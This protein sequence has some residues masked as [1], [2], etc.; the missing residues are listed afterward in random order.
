[1]APRRKKAATREVSPVVESDPPPAA[2]RPTDPAD[3][4]S[5]LRDDTIN[6]TLVPGQRLKLEDLR[7]RYNASV[8]S[9]RETLMQMV[10]EGLVT[11]ET[12]RGFC[13]APVSL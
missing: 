9:L 11:A 4:R 3:L 8:G 10:P 2:A 7:N 1:M 12:N 5:R 13:V 6:G